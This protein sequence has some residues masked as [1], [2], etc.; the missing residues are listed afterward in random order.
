MYNNKPV[1][2]KKQN[3]ENKCKTN[4]ICRRTKFKMGYIRGVIG[5]LIIESEQ[6]NIQLKYARN[7]VTTNVTQDFQGMF[8]QG[9]KRNTQ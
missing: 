4:I 6:L 3:T 2:N 5:Q 7:I 8:V 9:N 1:Y